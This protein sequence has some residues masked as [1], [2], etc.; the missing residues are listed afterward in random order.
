MFGGQ[1][2][3]AEQFNEKQDLIILYAVE[4]AL[5][6]HIAELTESLRELYVMGYSLPTTSAFIYQS[7][8]K[9]LQAIFDVFLPDAHAKDF[10]EMDIASSGIMRGF[11]S[12]PCDVYFGIDAKVSRFLECALK[13]YD[14]PEPKRKAAVA[15]VLA[16][17]LHSMAA[18]IIRKTVEEAE[19]GFKALS[20]EG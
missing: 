11:M 3:L 20:A 1:F 7:T 9:R 13:I 4:T 16:M 19:A 8:S 15:A 14:V 18:G 10:Y 17:E 12:V 2:A 5:Q 6:L